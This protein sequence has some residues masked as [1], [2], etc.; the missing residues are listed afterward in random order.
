MRNVKHLI[1][2]GLVF[3][4]AAGCE[5]GSPGL[6][7]GKGKW[8][9]FDSKPP[10][11]SPSRPTAA[12]SVVPKRPSSPSTVSR[13][14]DP[15][16]L[17]T[18][19]QVNDQIEQMKKAMERSESRP[20]TVSDG[21]TPAVGDSDSL[22]AKLAQTPEPTRSPRP[23]REDLN[24]AKVSER[25]VIT[26]A[27]RPTPATSPV[28]RKSASPA[29][30][31]NPQTIRII[32]VEPVTTPQ[33][34]VKP[35]PKPAPK[36]EIKPL[37]SPVPK[38]STTP[39]ERKPSAPIES[40]GVKAD[41]ASANTAVKL[42]TPPE[43]ENPNAAMDMLLFRL[44]QKLKDRP[45]DTATQ[46]KLRLVYAILGQWQQAMK[47]KDGKSSVGGQMAKSLASLVK[48]FDNTDLTSA[49]QATQALEAVEQIQKLLRDQADLVVSALQMCWRVDSFGSY[50]VIPPEYLVAGKRLPVV[51]YLELEN[52][53]SKPL[54][55]KTYQTLLS[56]TIEVL[57]E[58][59]KVCWRQPYEKIEDQAS[60]QRRD[61]YLA[62]AVTLPA[63][64]PEGRLKLKVTVEDLHGNKVAQRTMDFTL[65]PAE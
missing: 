12:S 44:E 3:L 4:S 54:P 7:T 62:P 11:P 9:M 61:F 29:K 13:R 16:V 27:K 32:G 35:S 46:V 14:P 22:A 59:G 30:T 10:T 2:A 18:E 51:V 63:T 5:S 23:P 1:I 60:K 56:L 43:I 40:P 58:S 39:A 36:P 57:K 53:I 8:R 15:E 26:P 24:K 25:P 50:K 6:W 65:K 41:P 21:P 48:T 31:P 47:D 52:F 19:R 17:R 42:E 55:S 49:Q 64:L 20:R 28:Q 37:P 33:A 34:N 45:D 38:P